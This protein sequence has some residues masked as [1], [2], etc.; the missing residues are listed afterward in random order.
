VAQDAWRLPLRRRDP[1]LR[2]V[3]ESQADA[4]LARMPARAGLALEVQRALS[5][6]IVGGDTRIATL[7]RGLAMSGR[8]LQRRLTAEGASYHELLDEVR[9]EAAGR[10]ISEPTLAIGDVAY[11]LGCSEPAPFHRAFKRWY[12]MT[13]DVF[14]Q[15]QRSVA[16]RTTPE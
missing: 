2:Q 8:T 12:G 5:A 1:V 4:M 9:K 13:P 14:R 6:C 7:A 11:L 10:H 16:A 15:K 3:L